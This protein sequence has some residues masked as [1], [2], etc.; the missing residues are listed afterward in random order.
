LRIVNA[1]DLS[2]RTVRRLMLIVERLGLL[3]AE[4]FASHEAKIRNQASDSQ[5]WWSG[6]A[7]LIPKS[8]RSPISYIRTSQ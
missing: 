2:K 1:V 5:I 8:Y 6:F 3:D 7:S 4:F